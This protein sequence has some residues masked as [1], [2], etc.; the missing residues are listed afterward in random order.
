MTVEEQLLLN[1]LSKE[2]ER[3]HKE[4]Q[5]QEDEQI[6]K[7]DADELIRRITEKAKRPSIR[8]NLDICNGLCGA[9]HIIYDMLIESGQE[10]GELNENT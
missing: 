9:V 5:R 2:C 4:L 1:T 10:K 6:R 7:I 8:E 3:L